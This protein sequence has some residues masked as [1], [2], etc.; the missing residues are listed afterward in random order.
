MDRSG[1]ELCVWL[2]TALDKDWTKEAFGLRVA[3]ASVPTRVAT[4]LKV[5]FLRNRKTFLLAAGWDAVAI[6]VA[7]LWFGQQF[8]QAH[9][10]AWLRVFAGPFGPPKITSGAVLTE[11]WRQQKPLSERLRRYFSTAN[12]RG[13]TLVGV[14]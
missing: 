5:S 12:F 14:L 9:R 11:P 4:A 10:Y 13:L 6:A 1:T 8:M 2:H 7:A 3:S